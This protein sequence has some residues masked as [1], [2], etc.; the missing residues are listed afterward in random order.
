[1]K[2]LLM[3]DFIMTWKYCKSYLLLVAAFLIGSVFVTVNSFLTIY[4]VVLS[5][6]LPFSICAY[7]EKIK[8][9]MYCDAL[10]VSRKKAVVSKYVFSVICVFS[11]TLA[12]AASLYIKMY[13]NN[14]VDIQELFSTVFVLLAV[15]LVSPGF[16]LPFIFKYS[17]EKARMVYYVTVGVVCAMAAILSGDINIPDV[18]IYIAL[19]VA[20]VFFVI[21]CF[22]SIKLYEKR[23]L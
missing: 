6:M 13:L 9:S 21:S 1:M 5:S 17:V 15:A 14:A 10:P 3:K 7:D 20:I 22:I 19:A 16:M 11:V 2:G 4:P 12:I 18:P 23:D 8:W